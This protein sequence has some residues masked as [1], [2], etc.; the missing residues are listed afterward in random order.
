M[1]ESVLSYFPLMEAEHDMKL[2]NIGYVH[3][4]DIN[5]FQEEHVYSLKRFLE[6]FCF[7]DL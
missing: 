5:I 4:A 2:A 6:L 7:P 3:K 1:F